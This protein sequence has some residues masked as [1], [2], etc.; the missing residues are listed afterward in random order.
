MKTPKQK[1]PKTQSPKQ[2][3]MDE[4]RWSGED[5]QYRRRGE[6]GKPDAGKP[7]TGKDMNDYFVEPVT[8]KKPAQPKQ[9]LHKGGIVKGKSK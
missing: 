6:N 4:L 5:M 1:L 2:R 7:M 9:A 8:K 3:Y